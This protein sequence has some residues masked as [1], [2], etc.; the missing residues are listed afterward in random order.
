MFGLGNVGSFV[1]LL[2]S[3]QIILLAQLDGV[4][5]AAP[6]A[7]QEAAPEGFGLVTQ[8]LSNPFNLILISA[9]LFMF[10]VVR[11]QQKQMK[12]LQKSLAEMKKNDR[13]ITASGIHGVVVQ[14]AADEP[15]VTI[16]VDESSGARLT[17]NRDAI[18]KIITPENKSNS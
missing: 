16:R 15:T 6:D 7:A 5:D 12:Q 10:I 9:I 17:V 13:I 2:W 4:P 11:P 18:A 3:G 1:E 14:A 8:F